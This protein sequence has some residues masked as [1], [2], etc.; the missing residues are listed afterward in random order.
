MCVQCA[1]CVRKPAEFGV[2]RW[3]TRCAES[4]SV[5]NEG[6]YLNFLFDFFC[7]RSYAILYCTQLLGELPAATRWIVME[8]R[9]PG[10]V[11]SSL[12]ENAA[13]MHNRAGSHVPRARFA[14]CTTCVLVT[15]PPCTHSCLPHTASSCSHPVWLHCSPPGHQGHGVSRA[16]GVRLFLWRAGVHTP[17]E[18][19][20]CWFAVAQASSCALVSDSTA[21]CTQGT[22]VVPILQA[23]TN[24]APMLA[25]WLCR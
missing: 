25:S 18:D 16:P 12:P 8:A 17:L 13:G 15:A 14:V 20:A 6:S 3:M 10:H 23:C 21:A 2:L 5:S 9:P 1:G 11:S 24:P 19:V 22:C 4:Q 7:S